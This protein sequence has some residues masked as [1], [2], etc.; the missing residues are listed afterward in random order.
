MPMMSSFLSYLSHIYVFDIPLLAALA[1]MILAPIA[2]GWIICPLLVL[3]TSRTHG[4]AKF[5][6]F[7]IA[8]LFSWLGFAIFLIFTQKPQVS[9]AARFD[10]VEPHF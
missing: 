7:I 9:E 1:L 10:P 5:G 3:F 8:F 2:C 6:W 4:G